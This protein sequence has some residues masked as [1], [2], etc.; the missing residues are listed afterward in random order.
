LRLRRRDRRRDLRDHAGPRGRPGAVHEQEASGLVSATTATRATGVARADGRRPSTTLDRRA[1]WHLI[2]RLL[3]LG[4]LIGLVIIVIYPM[5][6]MGI[7]SLKTNT[8]ILSDPFALPASPDL[9]S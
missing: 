6:W 3:V 2:G 5:L 4:A 1:F 9:S 8:E 7:G